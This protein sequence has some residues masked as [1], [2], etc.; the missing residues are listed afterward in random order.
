MPRPTAE[1]RTRLDQYIQ[2]LNRLG[3]G[4]TINDFRLD[5]IRQAKVTARRM[6]LYILVASAFFLLMA[7][8]V[9]LAQPLLPDSAA[10][11]RLFDLTS[12]AAWAFALGGLGAVAS[13]F[14]HMLKLL[15]Q[16][17]LRTS[18]E[19]ELVGRLVLGCLF[20]TVLS[21]TLTSRE[22][23]QFFGSLRS[24]EVVEGG[25]MLLLPFLAGYSIPL[26]LG[27]LDKAIRAVELTVG[28]DDRRETVARR[29]TRRGR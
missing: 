14:L 29:P 10:P 24:T 22:L 20:S 21:I 5:Q 28:L 1:A 12:G 8:G 7:F 16:E 19:F 18:D 25:A 9:L 6:R 11:R 13:I 3:D 4:L 23:I 27:L 2:S 26:V 15:P 17:T